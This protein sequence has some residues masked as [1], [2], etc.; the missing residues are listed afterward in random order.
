MAQDDPG[1]VKAPPKLDPTSAKDLE[2]KMKGDPKSDEP[3]K[4]AA[5]KDEAKKDDEKPKEEK[6]KDDKP[7]DDKPK[8]EGKKDDKKADAPPPKKAEPFDDGDPL[9]ADSDYYYGDDPYF[10][11]R[12]PSRQPRARKPRQTQDHSRFIDE[13]ILDSLNEDQLMH[14]MLQDLHIHDEHSSHRA[15]E[16]LD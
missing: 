13:D 4:A 8:E 15:I 12:G 2:V 6:P 3:P 10:V 5:K 9:I 11:R 7:K 1:E 16:Y 14:R